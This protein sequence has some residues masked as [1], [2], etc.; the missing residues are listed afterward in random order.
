[1]N[2]LCALEAWDIAEKKTKFPH[3]T[4]SPRE[5]YSDGGSTGAEALSYGSKEVEGLEG[6]GAQSVKAVTVTEK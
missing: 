3:G 5:E 2:P 1:V 6:G 4:Q